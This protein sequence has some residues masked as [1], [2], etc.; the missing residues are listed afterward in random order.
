MEAAAPSTHPAH[1]GSPAIPWQ[2]VIFFGAL[3]A[4]W[5]GVFNVLSSEWEA[6]PQ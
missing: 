5:F 1:A 4:V 3:A 2:A 6:N